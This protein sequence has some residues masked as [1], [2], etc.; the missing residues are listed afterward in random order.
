MSTL[1]VVAEVLREVAPRA[2]NARQIVELANGR[3]PTASRT[4]ETVVSRDLA[5]DVRDK[6]AASRFLRVDRGEFLLKEALPA[7]FYNDVEPYAAAWTRN[8][9]AAGEIAAGVVD[10]RSIRDIK[11]ADV[12]SYRQCHFFSG[13]GV[14]SRALRDAGWPDDCHVWSGSCPCTPFSSAGRKLGFADERHLWP[15][16]FRLIAACRP[17]FVFGEQVSSK[18]GLAWLDAVRVDLEGANYTLRVLDIPAAC[19]GA[20]HARHRLYFVAYARERSAEVLG[21][22]WLRERTVAVRDELARAVDARDVARERGREILSAAWLHDRG[23]PGYDAPRCREAYDRVSGPVSDASSSRPCVSQ[24]DRTDRGDAGAGTET[25]EWRASGGLELERSGPDDGPG[26]VSDTER[27]VRDAGRQCRAHGWTKVEPD[28]HGEADGSGCCCLGTIGMGDAGLA[29][30]GRDS[31]AVPRAQEA[32]EGERIEVG[33][34]ADQ[35][36]APGTDDGGI[37]HATDSTVVGMVR[38]AAVVAGD[39]VG[40]DF[41]P[42]DRIR[43]DGD[44]SW[45]GAV[46]G[47]WAV[48]VEWIYCRPEPGHKDGRWRPAQ[49]GIEPLVAGPSSGVGRTRAKRLRC[50]GNSIVLPLATT[51]VNSVFDAFADASLKSTG[52]IEAPVLAAPTK[53]AVPPWT[54]PHAGETAPS[55]MLF[56]RVPGERWPYGPP[57][58]HEPRCNLFPHRGSPGGLFCDCAASAADDVKALGG[59][60]TC[61]MKV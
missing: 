2:L 51:F 17:A 45:G 12:A 32:G 26:A 56:G 8:L 6:E 14:W 1:D 23:Q 31:R 21:A 7:A 18:D 46:R 4:P 42:G 25:I 50:F 58:A 57:S 28:R 3:L 9:I 52:P 24:D 53:Q 60:S 61:V 30:G 19:A 59:G 38:G 13:I 40:A 39:A 20:P 48:D 27:V 36:V 49:S 55:G 54:G 43:I 35:P 22:S 10:E 34:L 33:D 44:P 29:R 15:E 41:R 47:F 11:P 37:E 16:W 5:I